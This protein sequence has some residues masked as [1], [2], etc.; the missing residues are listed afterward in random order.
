IT[1]TERFHGAGP[2][3]RQYHVRFGDKLAQ[4]VPA[5]VSAQVQAQTAFASIADGEVVSTTTRS[6]TLTCAIEECP[7]F[8]FN[9][10]GA[11]I[12]SLPSAFAADDDDP[13]GQHAYAPQRAGSR[14]DRG[15]G[16]W[17]RCVG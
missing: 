4:Q 15:A 2:E 7:V 8:D 17:A 11:L 12:G 5:C 1:H 13:Q 9:H 10:V 16:G 3:I 14:P 6:I